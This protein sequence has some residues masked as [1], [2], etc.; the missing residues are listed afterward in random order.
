[1]PLLDRPGVWPAVALYAL[2]VLAIGAWSA[3]RTRTPRDFWIAGQGIGLLVTGLATTSAA[4]SG[5]VFVGGP[6]LTYRLGAS[7]FLICVSVSFT[8]GLLCWVVGRPLRLLAE[9]REVLTVPD[10]VLARYSSRWASGL[11]AVAV[12]VGCIGYLG[13]Q[14]LALGVL[15]EGALGTRGLGT[16]SLPVAMAVGLAVLVAY[17]AA[18]GMIAGVYTDVLQ[19]ALMVA[20][21]VAVFARAWTVT[22]GGAE[23]VRRLTASAAFGP[24]F[25]D[26]LGGVPAA[27]ALGFFFVFGVGVLGQP[28]MLHK[29]YMLD[30]PRK[31][32]WLPWVIALSQSLCLLIWVGIGLA[33]PALVAAGDLPPLTNPDRAAPVFLLAHAPGALAGL[34][35]AGVVAAIMSTADSMLSV[36]AAALVRDLPKALGRRPGDEL[37]RGRWA[38][39]GLALAAAVVAWLYG[40]LVALLGT[41]AFGTFA[42]ALAPALGG[43][44]EL[45]EGGGRG[46]R[47]VDRDGAGREPGAR[48][49]GAA[50]VPAGRRVAVGDRVDGVVR[51]AGGGG[52]AAAG[53][54]AGG[55]DGR[56]HGELRGGGWWAAVAAAD[57]REE[58]RAF[59]T[60]GGRFGGRLRWGSRGRRLLRR[61]ACGVAIPLP[62]VARR[63]A[64]RPDD[65]GPPVMPHL[66]RA[67]AGWRIVAI[68][69]SPGAAA[70]ARSPQ[71]GPAGR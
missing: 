6:G 3:R 36:G 51:G 28:H 58:P 18:G 12:V 53:G 16:W 64:N 48:G 24:H 5:F 29:F 38:V 39:V 43:G 54:R 70:P 23:V 61:R 60:M 10:A 1:M 55:G 21:A 45:G 42:A 26:P 19:G 31:L 41:L 13:A 35:L 11:A 9:V 27:T 49:A 46:G 7:S 67:T 57:F 47:G 63:P 25:L 65:G 52:L 50:R 32:R 2:A 20:A 59:R 22:G 37:R 14:V 15:L 44:V 68:V 71:T 30:D 66:A 17:S 40:D 34:V 33:V 4:F 62:L 56:G 8:A 69:A